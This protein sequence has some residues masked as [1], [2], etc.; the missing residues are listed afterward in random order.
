METGRKMAPES[1]NINHYNW[2][3]DCATLEQETLRFDIS[4]YNPKEVSRYSLVINGREVPFEPKCA[5]TQEVPFSPKMWMEPLNWTASCSFPANEVSDSENRLK[6]LCDDKSRHPIDIWYRLPPRWLIIP[7]EINIKRVSGRLANKVTY[8][9]GGRTEYVRYKQL[10]EKYGAESKGNLLD[11]GVGCGRVAQHF[12]K[13]CDYKVTGIDIDRINIDWCKENIPM[14]RSHLV[15]L[16]PPTDLPDREFDVVI[17][18]SVLSHL[19]PPHWEAWLSEISRVMKDGAMAFLS[20]H[21]DNSCSIILADRQLEALLDAG[22]VDL[23]ASPDLGKD[24]ER[25][26]RNTFYLDV[27]AEKIFEKYFTLIEVIPGF[28]SGQQSVAVLRK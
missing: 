8:L 15:D 28:L 21:G 4:G 24:L 12:I 11:W 14:L 5:G 6:L 16:L 18:S 1:P 9:N 10:F 25:Y 27:F 23:N 7:D 2:K 19:I 3:V 20:F 17:S 26:Y 13:E 22:Y